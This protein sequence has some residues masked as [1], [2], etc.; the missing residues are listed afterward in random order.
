MIDIL[1]ISLVVSAVVALAMWRLDWALGLVIF[2]LPFYVIRFTLGEIP[3]TMTEIALITLA[4]VFFGRRRLYRLSF[5]KEALDRVPFKIPLIIFLVMASWSVVVS[6]VRYEALGV[7]RAYFIEAVIF[8]FIFVNVVRCEREQ[9]TIMVALGAVALMVSL[10][11]IIQN[12]TG[13]NI[14]EPWSSATVRRVTAWYGYPVAVAL[15][16]T[17]LATFFTS[18]FLI[19]KSP[20]PKIF[21]L[22]VATAG[23]TAVYFTHSRGAI[24]AWLAALIGLSLVPR[25]LTGFNEKL[26]RWWRFLI[27]IGVAAGILL[28][29]LAPGISERFTSVF[30]GTDNSTNVRLV[31]WQGTARLIQEHWLWGA[32]LAGFPVLYDQYREARHTELLLYPHNIVLNFWVEIGLAGLIAFFWLVVNVFQKARAAGKISIQTAPVV[33]S[34][35]A[36]MV[37][38]LVQGLIDVPYFKNDLSILFWIIVGLITTSYE[39][40]RS[41]SNKESV[42]RPLTKRA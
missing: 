24:I 34:A 19:Q 8:F 13:L 2:L 32:G 1:V 25:R 28:L 30:M 27:I 9:K 20:L 40:N 33:L 5:L 18:L 15:F 16:L 36:A 22:T 35:S 3:F 38:L 37:A 4:I 39:I 23:L 42:R 12:F 31:M 21:C 29:F 26:S 17:P 6:P 11:A 41:A 10:Y 14:P 7:W